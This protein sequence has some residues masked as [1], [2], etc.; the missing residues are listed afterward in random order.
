MEV[1]SWLLSGGVPV[2]LGSVTRPRRRE[3]GVVVVD[4][5]VDGGSVETREESGDTELRLYL[6]TCWSRATHLSERGGRRWILPCRRKEMVEGRVT[7]V[8]CERPGSDT[9]VVTR[10]RLRTKACG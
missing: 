2:T 7:S 10:S 1:R 5:N 9:S 6:S 8:S 3:L 4:K